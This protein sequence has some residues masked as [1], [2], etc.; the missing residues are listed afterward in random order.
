[1]ALLISNISNNWN[2]IICVCP[3]ACMCFLLASF[4]CWAGVRFHPLYYITA[5]TH[6]SFFCR[7]FVADNV[8]W[9]D[10]SYFAFLCLIWIMMLQ[11]FACKFM[12]GHTPSVLLRISSGIELLSQCSSTWGKDKTIIQTGCKSSHFHQCAWVVPLL[13]HSICKKGRVYRGSQFEGTVHHDRE[14]SVSGRPLAGHIAPAVRN[15]S[16]YLG[17]DP[18]PWNCAT[19]RWSGSSHQN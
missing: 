10:V 15:L 11:T 18:S 3:C 7:L 12:H 1:M 8:S 9:M 17:R 19:H 5:R 13:R 4:F 6:S 14:G 2:Y 16:P